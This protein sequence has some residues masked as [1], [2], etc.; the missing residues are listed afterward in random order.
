MSMSPAR[1]APEKRFNRPPAVARLSGSCGVGMETIYNAAYFMDEVRRQFENEAV[2]HKFREAV[3]TAGTWQERLRAIRALYQAHEEVGEPAQDIEPY[4]LGLHDHWTPIE[5]KLWQDIRCT[6]RMHML[7]QY[8]VG[9]YFLDFANPAKKIGLEADG[10][11]FHDEARDRKRDQ[12]LWDEFGWRVFRVSGAECY[13]FRQ[14][15]AEFAREYYEQT[16]F[17]PDAE[18]VADAAVEFY[19]TTS[20]G[21]V[22]AVRDLMIRGAVD[23]EHWDE[24]M[25]GLDAHRLANFPI[26]GES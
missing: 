16:G 22:R 17:D 13:R 9:P 26:L 18:S 8:P 4:S 1:V 10:K 6:G 24:M 3:R 21:M 19:T 11:D 23:C 14:S 15:P 20:T 7:P 2:L 25:A 5:W 12:H